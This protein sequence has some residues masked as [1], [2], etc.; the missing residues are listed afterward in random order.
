MRLIDRFLDLVYPP[1]CI[2]CR[3]LLERSENG[4]CRACSLS[5]PPDESPERKSKFFDSCTSCY[6]Y[7]G[8]VRESLLRFKFKQASHYADIY[9]KFL[10]VRLFEHGIENYDLVTWVPVSRRRRRKRGYDQAELLARSVARELS[11]P[12]AATLEKF[13]DNPPQSHKATPAE[14]QA[15]VRGVYRIV[16][17]DAVKNK[18]ILLIDDIVTTGATL[19]ECGCVLALAGA[20]SVHCGTFAATS[21]K[22]TKQ[23]K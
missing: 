3:R 14:R 13:V 6:E 15:N 8:V 5:L 21:L 18:Q 4:I 1:K 9:G 11:L 19:S 2:F 16:D 10:A 12:I 17:A 7:S 20:A 22:L 23:V